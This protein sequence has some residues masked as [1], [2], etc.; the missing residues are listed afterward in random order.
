MIVRNYT[1][2]G[3]QCFK[4]GN[5][6][7]KKLNTFEY[8][9]NKMFN[10][11]CDSCNKSIASLEKKGKDK[12]KFS[13]SC[14][15]CGYSHSCTFPVNEFWQTDLKKIKCPDTNDIAFVIGSESKVMPVIEENFLMSESE[16]NDGTSYVSSYMGS[17]QI[18]D[19]I[20]HFEALTQMG[21]INCKCEENNLNLQIEENGIRLCCSY[22][23]RE[24]FFEV[25][26]FDELKAILSL[27]EINIE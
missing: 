23:G 22:C 27:S 21:K 16:E 7:N 19:V 11:L 6:Q 2:V 25:S 17:E 24:I 15:E 13:F 18:F 1:T 9:G 12:Y 3:F 20:D 14:V 10:I 8:S 26:S 5:V 4:C